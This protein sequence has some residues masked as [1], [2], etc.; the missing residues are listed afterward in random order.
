VAL[1][2]AVLDMQLGCRFCLPTFWKWFLFRVEMRFSNIARSIPKLLMIA[3][4][5]EDVL[6]YVGGSLIVAELS[7]LLQPLVP[8][9]SLLSVSTAR[10]NCED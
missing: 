5:E 8:K 6:L 10:S 9:G 4:C 7:T 3:C 2:L 1:G